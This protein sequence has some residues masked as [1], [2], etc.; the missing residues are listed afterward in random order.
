MNKSKI[1]YYLLAVAIFFLIILLSD[2]FYVIDETKQVV[3]TQFGKPI[4]EPIKDAGLHIKMPFIQDA[5][6]F[7]KRL[8]EWDGIPTEISA[9]DKVFIEIDTYARWKI[10]EPLKFFRSVRNEISAQARLANGL[11]ATITFADAIRRPLMG[12]R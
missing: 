7:E 3:I 1:L 2:A 10:V 8:L 5:N 6:Y 9:K 4:G 12:D 11:L